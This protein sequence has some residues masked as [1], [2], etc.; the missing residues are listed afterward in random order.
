MVAFLFLFGERGAVSDVE[1]KPRARGSRK[2]K[3]GV[4]A[5]RESVAKKAREHS[6]EIADGLIDKSKEGNVAAIKFTYETAAEDKELREA[7]ARAAF[8]RRSLATEWA[9]EP[10][11]S[12]DDAE[13]MAWWAGKRASMS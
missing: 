10:E 13:G 4:D 2:P 5:V 6:D 7:L 3:Y 1:R 12:G 8:P 9:S 11:W